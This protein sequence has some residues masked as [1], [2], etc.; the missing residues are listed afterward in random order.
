MS[1]HQTSD[2]ASILLV[3]NRYQIRGGEDS[4]FENEKRLLEQQGH[5][6]FTYERSNEELEGMSAFRKFFAAFASLFSFKSY[7]EVRK[8]IRE[9][10]IDILWVHNTLMRVSPSVYYAGFHSGI[11]VLQTVHN[12]RLFCPGAL[13]Y[14][15]EASAEKGVPAGKICTDCIEGGFS[16]AIKHKCYRGSRLQTA[17]LV[18]QLSLHRIL[19]TYKKLHYIC[20]TDFSKNLFLQGMG[21]HI[22]ASHVWVKPN[23]V[24]LPD[25]IIS[26]IAKDT[27]GKNPYYLYLGRLEKSK[28]IPWLLKEW[29]GNRTLLIAG[30]GTLK[31]AVE[32]ASRKNPCIHYLGALSHEEALR[33]LAGAEALLFPSEWYE[34]FPM[35]I[36]EAMALGTPVICRDIGNGAS[37]VKEIANDL[38]IQDHEALKDKLAVH[39]KKDYSEAFQKVYREKYTPEKNYEILSAIFKEAR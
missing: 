16:C 19:G 37:I 39:Q 21:K 1:E 7:R 22:D 31:E 2:K 17:F 35:V 34:N 27:E 24:N 13:C 11:P 32:E 8:L 38:V 25:E 12:F 36:L 5:R 6:V 9:H 4:V 14:R 28:G 23:F 29:E 33:Y 18:L 3:H 15:E 10:R 30:E 26:S 20:L